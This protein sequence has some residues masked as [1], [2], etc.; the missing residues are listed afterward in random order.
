MG[1]VFPSIPGLLTGK[2]IHNHSTCD[3]GNV[4]S[5]G[6]LLSAFFHPSSNVFHPADVKYGVSLIASFL[7]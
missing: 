4:V 6:P 1:D 3:D 7:R 2:F 5:N